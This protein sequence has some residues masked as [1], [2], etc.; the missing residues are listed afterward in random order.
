V[1]VQ[2]GYGEVVPPGFGCQDQ[3]PPSVYETRRYALW[4]AATYAVGP[5]SREQHYG[6]YAPK[7]VVEAALMFE[8]YLRRNG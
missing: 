2:D 7:E 3:L 1:T 5:H 6:G 8:A 4:C